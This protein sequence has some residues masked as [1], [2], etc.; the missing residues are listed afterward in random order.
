MLGV[1]MGA[2]AF[3]ALVMFIFW[4]IGRRQ[5]SW[6]N[7]AKEV[8]GATLVGAGLFWFVSRVWT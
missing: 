6:G 4:S 1:T 7:L 3:A 8:M 5:L 2:T